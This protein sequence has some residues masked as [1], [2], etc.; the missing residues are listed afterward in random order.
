[1]PVDPLHQRG[2][3]AGI[4]VGRDAVAQ[5]HHVPGR[6]FA[7]GE[8]V[9]GVRL[10]RLPAGGQQRGV[11]VALQRDAGQPGGRLVQRGAVVD[12]DGVR[13]HGELLEEVAGAG[14][15]VDARHASGDGGQRPARPGGDE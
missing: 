7:A 15:E 5:V 14:A 2:Q 4:G 9:E 13:A 1:M 8:H 6:G 3:D 11:D 10:Q 12:A